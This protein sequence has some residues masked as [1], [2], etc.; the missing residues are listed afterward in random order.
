MNLD[1][2]VCYCYHVSLRKLVN[3]SRRERPEPPSRM[4][5]CLNAGTGCGWCIPYLVRIATDPD[6]VAAEELSAD[7]YAQK[8]REY[9]DSG[10]PRN[11]FSDAD[12]REP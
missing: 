2:E 12:P 4:T 6:A 1:D 8:R 5:E 9:I 7:A 3:F 11:T 10:Q